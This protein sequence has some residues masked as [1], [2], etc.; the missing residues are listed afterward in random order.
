LFFNF[1]GAESVLFR[2]RVF[3]CELQVLSGRRMPDV[4]GLPIAHASTLPPAPD[5]PASHSA[6][7]AAAAA[8][9]LAAKALASTVTALKA[10]AFAATQAAAASS[11]PFLGDRFA[12]S[13]A[14]TSGTSGKD[15]GREREKLEQQRR[16]AQLEKSQRDFLAA[17]ARD[18]LQ[19]DPMGI[20]FKR[21]VHKHA[22]YA[23]Y[24]PLSSHAHPQDTPPAA[25]LL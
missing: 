14:A 22:Y 17:G 16:A 23:L 7:A 8:G 18:A 20:C 24:T 21:M 25:H 4:P 15:Q 11:A 2:E 19:G 5:K 9:E 6:D 12:A 10:T 3:A 1:T 13:Q